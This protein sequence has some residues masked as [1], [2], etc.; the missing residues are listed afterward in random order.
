MA[1]EYQPRRISIRSAQS[2][3]Y[4]SE[5]KQKKV[6]R[7]ALYDALYR[8]L[9]YSD[10]NRDLSMVIGKALCNAINE[11]RREPLPAEES[12]KLRDVLKPIVTE[13]IDEL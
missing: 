2:I 9:Q 12:D 1:S 4:D 8:I 3:Y 5:S 6:V 10:I 13:A 11:D 7:K